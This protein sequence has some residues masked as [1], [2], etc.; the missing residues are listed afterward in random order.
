MRV[1]DGRGFTLLELIVV[2]AAVGILAVLGLPAL[3]ENFW[4]ARVEGTAREAHAAM[5]AARFHAIQEGRPY[6]VFADFVEGRVV[7]FFWTDPDLDWTVAN[8]SLTPR[9]VD[10]RGIEFQGPPAPGDPAPVVG[11]DDG[12]TPAVGGWVV[13]QPDG[14][15]VIDADAVP[16]PTE[17][18]VRFA[19]LERNIYYEVRVGPAATGR[20]RV[21]KWNGTAFVD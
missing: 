11:F 7:E 9:Y 8:M 19:M 12:G 10:L 1:R 13:F 21:L 3:L 5:L 15:A 17:G 16:P 20:V 14:S 6:G 18:A 4:R 2:V